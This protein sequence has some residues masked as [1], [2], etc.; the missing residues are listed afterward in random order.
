MAAGVCAGKH[1]ER[2]CCHGPG[3]QATTRGGGGRA[4]GACGKKATPWLLLLLL[5]ACLSQSLLLTA[6]DPD[7]LQE[8]FFDSLA[9]SEDL[10]A[11]QAELA[12]NS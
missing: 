8:E 4:A 6:W 7:A 11:A 5:S 10:S 1:P 3:H 12:L 9:G 2:V